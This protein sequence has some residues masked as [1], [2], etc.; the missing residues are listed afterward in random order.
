MRWLAV[1]PLAD[2]VTLP[3]CSLP[4]DVMVVPAFHGGLLGD[5]QRPAHG[6]RLPLRPAGT[7][8]TPDMREAAE[9][10]TGAAAAWRMPDTRSACPG[11]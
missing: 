1:V 4:P 6:Q 5:R 10:I 8:A 2:A 11:C 7:A 3:V 9:V